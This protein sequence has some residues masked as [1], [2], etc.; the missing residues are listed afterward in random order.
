[1]DLALLLELQ[2]VRAHECNAER[3]R[4][5]A[6]SDVWGHGR[7]GVSGRAFS[8][9]RVCEFDSSLGVCAFDQVWLVGSGVEVDR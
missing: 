7:L 8:F 3:G 4:V 2:P 6:V 1:M 9:E 5:P